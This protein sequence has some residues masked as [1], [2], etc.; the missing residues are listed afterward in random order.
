MDLLSRVLFSGITIMKFK[1]EIKRLHK[2]SN[3]EKLNLKGQQFIDSFNIYRLMANIPWKSSKGYQLPKTDQL[4][5][6][7][8]I[9]K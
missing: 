4:M 1:T 5:T 8:E 2:T 7:S 6:S 9:M 3:S